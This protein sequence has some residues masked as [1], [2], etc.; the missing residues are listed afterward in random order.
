MQNDPKINAANT[1]WN[2]TGGNKIRLLTRIN[3]RPVNGESN[4]AVNQAK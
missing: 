2:E 4:D 1:D 3:V